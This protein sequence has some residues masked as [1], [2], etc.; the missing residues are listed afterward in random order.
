[1]RCPFN[2]AECN[3]ECALFIAPN[4]LNE[5]VRTRL[6]TI[7]VFDKEKGLCSLK[8]LALSGSR[9]MYEKTSTFSRG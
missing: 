1:M 5:S 2:N 4:D 8:G 3:N 9:F 7:G 6:T